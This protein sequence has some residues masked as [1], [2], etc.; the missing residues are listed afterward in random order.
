M[1]LT[2]ELTT[3]KVFSRSPRGAMTQEC[4]AERY[5]AVREDESAA[6]ARTS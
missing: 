5:S 3:V 4:L 1:L 2:I 6:A